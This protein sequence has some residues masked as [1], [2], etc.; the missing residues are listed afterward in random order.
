MDKTRKTA[1]GL[2]KGLATLAVGMLIVTETASALPKFSS[3]MTIRAD[4]GG[5]VITY[6]I[7]MKELQEAGRDVRFS[8]P[9]DSACTLY[10]A[11]PRSQTCITQGASFG[12]HLPYGAS[13]RG[14]RVAAEY[15]L[16][17]YPGWVKSWI[18][19]KGGLSSGIKRM[20]YAHASKYLPTCGG[21]PKVTASAKVNSVSGAREKS[22]FA[23]RS[24]GTFGTMGTDSNSAHKPWRRENFR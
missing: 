13:A 5:E 21:T 20:D 16:R 10:L 2:C 6:A 22:S 1:I 12:F 4:R 3:A 24:M 15:M 9:C 8:G 18:Q 14:N 23:F 7:R 17:Q 11:L 19:R